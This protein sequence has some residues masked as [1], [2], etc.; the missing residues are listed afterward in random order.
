MKKIVCC[1]LLVA[2]SLIPAQAQV[3][4]IIQAVTTKVIMAIDL[5]VQ[6]LQNQTIWLQDAQKQL[7]NT[8]SQLKLQEIGSWVQQEKDLYSEYY[9]ELSQV[10]IY[11]TEYDK[12]KTLISQQAAI[13]SSYNQAMAQFKQDP[14]FTAA[15]LQHMETVYQGILSEAVQW[16]DQATLVLQA[17]VTSM[18]DQQRLQKINE[19]ASKT[20][21]SYNAMQ[22]FTTQNQILSLQRSKDQEEVNQVLKLYNLEQ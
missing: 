20:T 10:K 9:N 17:L 21:V 12:V 2:G 15:E 7:E 3:L 5:G 16:L 4:E 19:A 13:V 1:F 22:Q 14:H 11:I 8:L 18:T 6:K